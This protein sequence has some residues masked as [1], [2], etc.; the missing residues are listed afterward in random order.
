MICFSHAHQRH[1]QSHSESN[2][3][4]PCGPVEVGSLGM[5]KLYYLRIKTKTIC[6]LPFPTFRIPV[7]EFPRK[8][9]YQLKTKITLD[10]FIKK[11]ALEINLCHTGTQSRAI[12]IRK[13]IEI[14][15]Q[16][17]QN[18]LPTIEAEIFNYYLLKK[19]YNFL[20]LKRIQRQSSIKLDGERCKT[21]RTES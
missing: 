19:F 16:F 4:D 14:A 1:I 10:F 18:I 8:F 17:K 2:N 15:Q 5:K 6:I 21:Q 11:I 13:A 7:V 20:E 3:I 12:V 9:Q